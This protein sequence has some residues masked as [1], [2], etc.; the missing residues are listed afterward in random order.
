MSGFYILRMRVWLAVVS[1]GAELKLFV[2]TVL[3]I[4]IMLQAFTYSFGN[5][6]FK[7]SV[8]YKTLTAHGVIL[9]LNMS[10]G[11]TRITRI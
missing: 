11:I 6:P 1:N 5:S 10:F 7:I 3:S 2:R 8:H 9:N 4:H